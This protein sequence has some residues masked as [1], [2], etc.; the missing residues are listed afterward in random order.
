MF[1]IID[2]N[3]SG[4]ILFLKENKIFIVLFIKFIVIIFMDTLKN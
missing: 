1:N 2:A 4:I 3:L